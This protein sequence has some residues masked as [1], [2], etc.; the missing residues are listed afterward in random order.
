MT[1]DD[2]PSSEAGKWNSGVADSAVAWLYREFA[3]PFRQSAHHDAQRSRN[4]PSPSRLRHNGRVHTAAYDTWRALPFPRGS[5]VDEIDEAHAD[6]AYW[7]AM[8]LEAIGPMVEYPVR[9]DPGVL[10]LRVGLAALRERLVAMRSTYHGEEADL[11]DSYV[12]YV[13]VLAAVNDWAARA[14][15]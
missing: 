11:L 1:S 7:D 4:L 13:D 6:L 2:R 3:E 5:T 9:Y 10:D 12:R 15:H 8:T 14:L